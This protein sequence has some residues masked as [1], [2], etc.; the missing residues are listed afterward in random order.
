MY[1]LSGSMFTQLLCCFHFFFC[2]FRTF[3]VFQHIRYDSVF[4]QSFGCL[5]S[6]TNCAVLFTFHCFWFC[7][8][9]FTA[10]VH[11]YL[12]HILEGGW[13]TL[14][15]QTTAFNVVWLRMSMIWFCVCL[16]LFIRISRVRKKSESSSNQCRWNL[17]NG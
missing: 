10:S 13:I 16:L 11:R 9:F 12:K 4:C 6:N 15:K 7:F 3:H 17:K 14:K 8:P 1:R 2:G 5:H